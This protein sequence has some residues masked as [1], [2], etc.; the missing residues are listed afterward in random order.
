MVGKPNVWYA[1]LIAE[2]NSI[3]FVSKLSDSNS[4]LNPANYYLPKLSK[5]TVVESLPDHSSNRSQANNHIQFC[6]SC[7]LWSNQYQAC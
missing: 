3:K 5:F 1:R 2:K 7:P 6:Y 4:E